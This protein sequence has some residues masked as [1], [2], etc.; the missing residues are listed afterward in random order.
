MAG[1]T[2]ATEFVAAPSAARDS[3]R[4]ANGT[5][6]DDEAEVAAQQ[7]SSLAVRPQSLLLTFCAHFLL[8]Q[9]GVLFTGSFVEALT[10]AGVG[11]HAARTTLTRMCQR[12]LL[13]RSR[14]GAKVYLSLTTRGEQVLRDAETRVWSQ[15]AVN[16]SWS[17]EWTVLSFSL[18]ESR[19]AERHQLRKRLAWEGFGMLHSGLWITPSVVDVPQL[20]SGSNLNSEVK[21][22]K[23]AALPPTDVHQLVE[24][25]WDLDA[26]SDGY[27]RFLERWGGQEPGSGIDDA[28]ARFLLLLTEWLLLVRID[29]HLP[30]ALLPPDWPAVPA[31][32]LVVRLRKAYEPAAWSA[33][34]GF[35]DRRSA[36]DQVVAGRAQK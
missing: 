3:G 11:E 35:A 29:P 26:L 4:G 19:R 31:E 10:R 13:A 6:H 25:A 30:A 33:F 32:R 34:E 12:G 8:D 2:R 27:S 5:D 7:G 28:L 16:R 15:G 21:V 22:F 24:D 36:G 20:L 1:R 14:I 18:P 17:G 23:G 9:P